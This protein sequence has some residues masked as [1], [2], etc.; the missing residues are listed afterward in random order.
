ME[1]EPPSDPGRK[2]VEEHYRAFANAMTKN[3]GTEREFFVEDDGIPDSERVA[4]DHPYVALFK[5]LEAQS[6]AAIPVTGLARTRD[7]GA[8]IAALVIAKKRLCVRLESDDF[9]GPDPLPKRLNDLVAAAH[10]AKGQIDLIV[11]FGALPP[12]IG[13]MALAALGALTSIPD[14]AGW[15]SFTVAM[16]SFPERPSAHVSAASSGRLSRDAWAVYQRVLA[17]SL[18]RMPDFGDYAVDNPEADLNVPPAVLANMMTANIRYST[19]T[20]WLIVRGNRLKTHGFEQYR[21]LSASLMREPEYKGT[22]FSW[23]DKYIHDCASST[24]GTGNQMTWRQVA[25][26]HH[27]TLV[28]EQ[29]SSLP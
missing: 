9:T 25:V 4:G 1:L 16:T 18:T 13:A 19:D 26:N 11:D 6:L 10:L 2:T 5:A 12:N 17:S 20:D 14:L 29:L 21:E 27:I 15:R 24:V 3:W 8:A 23:G 7:Y 22:A 28:V